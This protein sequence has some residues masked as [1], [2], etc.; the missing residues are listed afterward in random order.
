[1]TRAF[2]YA[3]FPS[4]S[5]PSPS[6][7]SVQQRGG[8][9]RR[10]QRKK[11]SPASPVLPNENAH[12]WWHGDAIFNALDIFGRCDRGVDGAKANSQARNL[13]SS[14]HETCTPRVTDRYRK[15]DRYSNSLT[16][17]ASS[18][19]ASTCSREPRAAT[20]LVLDE[21]LVWVHPP[22]QYTAGPV[23]SQWH[24]RPSENWHWAGPSFSDL[25]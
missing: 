5:A 11:D 12:F 16:S 3:A 22:T 15:P 18:K 13:Y 21:P 2:F 19:E 9:H 24:L 25:D 20:F 17:R 23:S 8:R 4:R 1:M 10:P 14:A 7:A 6:R